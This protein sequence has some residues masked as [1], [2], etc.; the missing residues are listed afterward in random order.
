[1]NRIKKIFRGILT[2]LLI[3]IIAVT[4]FWVSSARYTGDY[5]DT[6]DCG[7]VFFHSITKS[8]DLSDESVK[9][10]LKA[11]QLYDESKLSNIIC[12]GGLKINFPRTGSRMM[13]DY[14][15]AGGVNA[16]NIFADTVSHSS[17]TNWRESL[18]IIRE[19][20]FKKIIIISSPSHI[21]RLK[22]ICREL[23]LYIE[24]ITFTP[25]SGIFDIFIDSNIEFG[26]W[27]FLLVLPE[28]FSDWVKDL[29]R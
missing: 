9:R 25:D 3:D 10:C 13:K 1:L 6:F 4:V 5:N 8:G 11:L 28:S 2:I 23:G 7:I 22:Y 19:K 12:T 16:Q 15:I 26:K 20:G 17:L 24:Y 29:I 18:K 14:M 21:L 27:I